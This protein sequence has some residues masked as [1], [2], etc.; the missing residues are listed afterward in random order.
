M[1]DKNP[2]P[3]LNACGY[4]T[5]LICNSVN[6]PSW[7]SLLARFA[8]NISM[9]EKINSLEFGSCIGPRW[10]FCPAHL[11]PGLCLQIWTKRTYF[12]CP[13]PC[14]GDP[15]LVNTLYIARLISNISVIGA[16]GWERGVLRLFHS[17][18]ALIT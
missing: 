13:I 7:Y 4:L 8:S 12:F 11:Q 14:C 5:V 3:S 17:F 2:V 16:R 6:M 9:S 15:F 18:M 10:P 1:K